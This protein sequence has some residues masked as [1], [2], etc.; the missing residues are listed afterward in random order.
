M[1]VSIGGGGGGVLAAAGPGSASALGSG[2][3]S[4]TSS[5]GGGGPGFP[6]SL[7]PPPAPPP[8][9]SLRI[10]DRLYS[11][12]L[13]TLEN[14]LLSADAVRFTPSMGS[15]LDAETEAQ[16]RVTGC[17]LIQAAGIL[18]RLPQVT[19]RDGTAR[20]RPTYRQGEEEAG[21]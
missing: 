3:S 15:G 13:I 1:A 16:L 20:P 4:S 19:P 17:E 2:S 5:S 21:T 12:V 14:C 8:P 7:P 18:L 11:G 6:L 10:G 9:G